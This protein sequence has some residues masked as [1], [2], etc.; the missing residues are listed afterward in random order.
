LKVFL[1]QSRDFVFQGGTRSGI[2]EKYSTIYRSIVAA[3]E[4]GT[5]FNADKC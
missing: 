3:N 1:I 5:T 4:K 2:T